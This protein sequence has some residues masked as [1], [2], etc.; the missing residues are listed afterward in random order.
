[1]VMKCNAEPM[2]G[3]R[4]ELEAGHGEEILHQK[5]SYPYGKEGKP[6]IFRWS[7]DSQRRLAESSGP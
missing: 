2:G 1:M 3:G 6:F 4:C 5:T 7:D